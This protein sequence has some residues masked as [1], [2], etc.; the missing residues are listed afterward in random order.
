MHNLVENMHAKFQLPSS[1]K[2][3][4]RFWPAFFDSSPLCAVSNGYSERLIDNILKKQKHKKR[5]QDSTTLIPAKDQKYVKLPFDPT[6]T[7]GLEGV[8]RQHNIKPCYVSNS[9]LKTLLGNPKDPIEPLQKSGI[10]KVTCPE[11]NIAYIGQ[12]RRN[13]NTRFK[14]HAACFR[15]GHFNK[16]S[17]AQHMASNSHSITIKDVSQIKHAPDHLLDFYESIHIQKKQAKP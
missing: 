15:L 13:L 12:T 2:S 16:S 14:E 5:I 3:I 6:S 9:K 1:K 8:F 7:K 4:L 11:C 10:Y 17:V